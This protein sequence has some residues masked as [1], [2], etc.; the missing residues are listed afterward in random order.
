MKLIV[1]LGNPGTK[2]EKTRHNVGFMVVEQF[3]KDFE[4]VKDT[5]WIDN[6]KFKSDIAEINWQPFHGKEE[7]VILAKPKTYMNNSG[8]AVQLLTSFYKVPTSDVWIVHDDIDLPI[9]SMKIRF[10]GGTA[11]H[12][13]AES[14]MEQLGTDKFW[15][16]RLGIGVKS[17][18]PE[19]KGQM[20]KNVEDFVLG[21]FTGAERGK[22]KDMVKKGS[23]AIQTGLEV[24]LES[25]MNRFNTK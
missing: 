19:A 21:N 13:G 6:K 16:F 18:R 10:G 22:V 2:Y 14:I 1:G 5:L 7:K 4:P 11:G 17:Q 12:H 25:A 9:G 8:L 3:L 15:R 24:G 20:I 23:K